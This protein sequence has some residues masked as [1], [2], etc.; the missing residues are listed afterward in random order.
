MRLPID[1]PDR[2]PAAADPEYARI[3][4]REL[5]EFLAAAR[6]LIQVHPAEEANV[7]R[8]VELVLTVM[9][10]QRLWAHQLAKHRLRRGTQAPVIP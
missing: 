10:R 8:F 1:T 4:E 6:T 5:S 7:C 3:D 9:S 2:P